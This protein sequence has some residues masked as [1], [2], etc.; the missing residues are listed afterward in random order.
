MKSW[1]YVNIE[2]GKQ[3][4]TTKDDNIVNALNKAI[5]ELEHKD[6]LSEE[7][8][9]TDLLVIFH[10]VGD[11]HQP[12]HTGYETDK[13][14][15]TVQVSF[16]GHHSNLHKIWD[17]EIIE[18]EHISTDDCLALCRN[19]SKQQIDQLRTINV[20]SW[21][22]QPRSLLADVYTFSHSNIDKQY[23]DKNKAVVEQQ[24]LIA[25]IRLSA[26]LQRVFTKAQ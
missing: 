14:G 21:L 3:Y 8:I 24:L 16:M 4:T 11:L 6:K 7:Q 19:F 12:L 2:K 22:Q 26:V 18:K 17:S 23:V 25:G 13:G 15:N 10:L 20:E 9:R 5:S 1:H